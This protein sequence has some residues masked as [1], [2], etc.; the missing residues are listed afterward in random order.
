MAATRENPARKPRQEARPATSVP[1]QGTFFAWLAQ[2]QVVA[3]DSLL[4]LA[5][6][7]GPALD[8]GTVRRIA[9]RA[10]VGGAWV[11]RPPGDLPS[12]LATVGRAVSDARSAEGRIALRGASSDRSD[13]HVRLAARLAAALEANELEVWY[14]PVVRSWVRG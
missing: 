9:V 13:A 3:V 2:H 5:A 14:Q 6:E 1:H 10:T 12:L 8:D 4:R 11:D 7:A